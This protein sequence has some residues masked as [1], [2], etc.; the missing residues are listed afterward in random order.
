MENLAL[1]LHHGLHLFLVVG[2][3][4]GVVLLP[5]PLSVSGIGLMN[6]GMALLDWT[7]VLGDHRG[8]GVAVMSCRLIQVNLIRVFIDFRG[9]VGGRVPCGWPSLTVIVC[10]LLALLGFFAVFFR[11]VD[12]RFFV[13]GAIVALGVL[14][15][16]V[17]KLTKVFSALFSLASFLDLKGDLLGNCRSL[18]FN[19]LHD[20]LRHFWVLVGEFLGLLS[21]FLATFRTFLSFTSPLDVLVTLAIVLH[22]RNGLGLACNVISLIVRMMAMVAV[23]VPILFVSFKHLALLNP[24]VILL[25]SNVV[26]S[27][28]PLKLLLLST[29]VVLAELMLLSVSLQLSKTPFL[30]DTVKLF[31]GLDGLF[32]ELSKAIL[33][34]FCGM[35]EIMGTFLSFSGLLLGEV[36]SPVKL[37]RFL[38]GFKP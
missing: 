25:L 23:E 12:I 11:L 15:R 20:L 17:A 35:L 34:F 24:H 37:L 29:P 33:G 3:L 27:P 30:F 14:S 28:D 4:L 16:V 13:Y 18:L 6:W 10:L 26:V 36:G 5:V 7:L 22:I 9:R 19:F 38:L 1:P 31:L 2:H 8:S 32:L 21:S